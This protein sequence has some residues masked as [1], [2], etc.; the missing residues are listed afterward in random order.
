MCLCVYRCMYIIMGVM[1]CPMGNKTLSWTQR[2]LNS[3]RSLGC[4][5]LRSTGMGLPL[6]GDDSLFNSEKVT[7]FES[8]RK[9]KPM[10]MRDIGVAVL[11]VNV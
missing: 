7:H 2:P 3:N 9:V 8:L 5:L 6:K 10:S 11:Y 4:D 1:D